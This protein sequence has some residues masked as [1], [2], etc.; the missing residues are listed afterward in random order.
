MSTARSRSG[1]CARA[2]R[3]GLGIS[4]PSAFALLDSAFACVVSTVLEYLGL[5][6]FFPRLRFHAPLRNV[7]LANVAG[8][9]V[10]AIMVGVLF[11]VP[12]IQ[13]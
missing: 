4:T 6:L 2:P 10:L 13:R 9:F 8:Y 3:Q 7:A 12:K 1:C 11:I 5:R